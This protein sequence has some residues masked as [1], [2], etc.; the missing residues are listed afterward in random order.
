MRSNLELAQMLLDEVKNLDMDGNRAL[1]RGLIREMRDDANDI[2]KP[3]SDECT[4]YLKSR[5]K[6]DAKLLDETLEEIA[7]QDILVVALA[8]YV[9]KES[10]KVDDGQSQRTDG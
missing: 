5:I 2:S 8:M 7:A 3:G 4:D 6:Q 10:E 9:V 1:V